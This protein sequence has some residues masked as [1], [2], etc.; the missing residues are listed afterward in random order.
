MSKEKKEKQEKKEEA[1]AS[2]GKSWFERAAEGVVNYFEPKIQGGIEI[3]I[4]NYIK[5]ASGGWLGKIMTANPGMIDAVIGG[6]S[7]L[8]QEW[9]PKSIA[10]RTIQQTMRVVP[11]VLA[12]QMARIKK[13]EILSVD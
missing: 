10:V 6:M 4:E 9:K 1:S 7:T 2:S 12:R 5:G 11:N 3:K 8:L 13:G